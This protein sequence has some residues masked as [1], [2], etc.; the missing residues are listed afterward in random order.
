LPG[1]FNYLGCTADFVDA[2]GALDQDQA[3]CFVE[4]FLAIDR[5]DPEPQSWFGSLEVVIAAHDE[6]FAK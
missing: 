5:S 6:A 1:L 2:S 4:A 3:R